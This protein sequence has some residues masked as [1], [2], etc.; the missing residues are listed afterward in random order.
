MWILKQLGKMFVRVPTFEMLEKEERYGPPSNHL[1]AALAAACSRAS[2]CCVPTIW[3][4][5]LGSA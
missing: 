2:C 5:C 1:W 3:S 4:S